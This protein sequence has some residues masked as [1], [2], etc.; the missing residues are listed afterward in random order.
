MTVE[1]SMFFPVHA[2]INGVDQPVMARIDGE[3]SSGKDSL[4]IGHEGDIYRIIHAARHD[5][6]ETGAVRAAPKDVRGFGFPFLSIHDMRLFGKRA[7]TPVNQ[8]VTAGI[9]TVQIVR[10]TGERSTFEPFDAL[11]G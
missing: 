10:A 8:S 3:K 5:G 1:Y 9:G 2:A 7:F 4:A 11:V 6:L